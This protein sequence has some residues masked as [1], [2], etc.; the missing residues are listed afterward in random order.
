MATT[1][2]K[3]GKELKRIARNIKV[4][5]PADVPPP[6]RLERALTLN[7]KLDH[8]AKATRA[9]FVVRVTATGRIGTADAPLNQAA[10][11]PP[12]DPATRNRRLRTRSFQRAVRGQQPEPL[13]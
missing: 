5:A 13:P 4:S 12:A 9:R 2:D 11:Q 3:K 8:D 1:F 10:T 7:F 6:G